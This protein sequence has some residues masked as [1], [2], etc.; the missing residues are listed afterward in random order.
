MP[1]ERGAAI[2]RIAE[3]YFI[4]DTTVSSWIRKIESEEA[5]K[6]PFD[7]LR[8]LLNPLHADAPSTETK[9]TR[10]TYPNLYYRDRA[11]RWAG[12]VAGMR[13]GSKERSAII[14]GIA[15]RNNVSVDT[16]RAWI[17]EAE[18]ETK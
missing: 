2:R 17:R 3:R 5:V 8:N 15:E 10:N 14:H 13:S 18:K 7:W 4:A 6:T 11:Q 12:E 1:S 9:Q 16:V